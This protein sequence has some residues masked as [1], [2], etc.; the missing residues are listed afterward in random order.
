MFIAG[1]Q[2]DAISRVGD[3]IETVHFNSICYVVQVRA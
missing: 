2:M 1:D 3:L